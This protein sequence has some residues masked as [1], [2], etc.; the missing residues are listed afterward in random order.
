M[1]SAGADAV[2]LED[3]VSEKGADIDQV[4]K[5]FLLMKWKIE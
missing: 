3:Q 1:I 2:H 4:K 5:L